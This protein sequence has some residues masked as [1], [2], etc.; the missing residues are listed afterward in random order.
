M[1][2]TS[3]SNLDTPLGS[4]INLVFSGKD[5]TLHDAHVFSVK[6]FIFA[7]PL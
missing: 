5:L 1:R 7:D 3:T 2:I 6:P 4:D